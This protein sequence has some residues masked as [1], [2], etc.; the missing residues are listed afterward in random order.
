MSG[1]AQGG[2]DP[3]LS[4]EHP[5]QPM[6]PSRVGSWLR[7]PAP[8]MHIDRLV[9]HLL[10]RSRIP[11]PPCLSLVRLSAAYQPVVPAVYQSVGHPPVL[12]QPPQPPPVLPPPPWASFTAC[13]P[14]PALQPSSRLSPHIGLYVRLELSRLL[15]PLP[16]PPM[17][18]LLAVAS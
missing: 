1:P 4:G 16:C 3:A 8:G 14:Q 11:L 9:P 2:T 12:P 7:V 5:S 10:L 6:C 18:Y 15:A 13:H 17:P